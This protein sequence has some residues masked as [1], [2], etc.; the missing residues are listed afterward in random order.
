MTRSLSVLTA[1][2]AASLAL[3]AAPARADE[4]L[5]AVAAN[6]TAAA[7]EIGAA[8]T[9]ATG[10]TATF[11]F[12]STGKLYAQI[13]HG[14]PF[15]AFLAADTARPEKAEAEG[16]GV[17]G[18]RFTY[19]VGRL[20][21]YSTDPALV[22]DAGAVLERDAF[23]HLA[24]ANPVTAPYGAAAVEVLEALGLQESLKDRLVQG[25]T[26]AQAHQ[27][28]ITGNAEIGFVA[29]SQVVDDDSGSQWMVPQD[30][31]TPI[32]QDAIL[33]KTGADNPVAA[34]F[35]AFL[36][37]PEATAITARYGYGTE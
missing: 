17:P 30:L 36:K 16:L 14:A 11:S 3:T 4:T 15:E 6:F 37:G 32:R 24:I 2:L 34:A 1:A 10:H 18:S 8:F 33:L 31:Y 9:E 22:D 29:L 28:V 13:A 23:D 26:I 12:G 5:V 19:A 20:V 35:L 25:D 27:F 7:K 21:L